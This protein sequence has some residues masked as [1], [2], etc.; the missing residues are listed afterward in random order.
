MLPMMNYCLFGLFSFVVCFQSTA[1]EL[2]SGWTAV[3]T[4][5]GG[6]EP[7]QIY[8][9]DLHS[10]YAISNS[11]DG[12]IF[13]SDFNIEKSWINLKFSGEKF[14]GIV[15]LV[16]VDEEENRRVI[17]TTPPSGRQGTGWLNEG[18]FAFDVKDF[19]GKQAHLQVT[20]IRDLNRFTLAEFEQSGRSRGPESLD[21]Y[22]NT[23]MERMKR[24]Q[25]IADSDP[26]RPVIHTAIPS[27]KSWDANG[28][29]YKDGLYH[30]FYLARPNDST[31]IMAHKV[32]PDLVHWEERLPAIVPSFEQGEEAVWSG[33][34]ILD[35]QGRCH[36]Y[37]TSVGPDRPTAC[38]PHQGHEVSVDSAFDRF[39]KVNPN[40]IVT[41]RDIPIPV[42][43]VRDPYVFRVGDRYYMTITG[44]T[45]RDEY[46]ED[47]SLLF[48]WDH[49]KE[50][51]VLM[52]F[53]SDDLYDWT[54][55]GVAYKEESKTGMFEVSDLF[56]QEGRWFFSPGGAY[57]YVG[58]FD[59]DACQFTPS[60]TDR[61]NTGLFYAYR[62][63]TAPDGRRLA[64]SR[65]KEGGDLRTKKWEGC[66]TLVREWWLQDDVLHQRPAVENQVLRQD[67]QTFSGTVDGVKEIFNAGTE[68]EVLAE[69]EA[70]SATRF[71]LQ[72]RRSDDGSQFFQIGWD[73][74]RKEAWACV[75]KDGEIPPHK[76]WW[77]NC[78]TAKPEN[79]Q[80]SRKVKLQ[81][82][83]DRGLVEV[84]V[85]DQKVI[86]LWVENIPLDCTG[87]AVFAEN[88]DVAVSQ[89]DQWTLVK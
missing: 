80:D 39:D 58:S 64:I 62:S 29:V 17:R 20:G 2:P 37:Y 79:K 43:Q 46:K 73:V 27:G 48:H 54:Y 30:F 71:G 22:V 78:L 75:L 12:A 40:M 63:M 16:T 34:A 25:S 3:G 31:P 7:A 74:T 41:D 69:L 33:S 70:G 85:D 51:P 53:E 1:A 59:F 49:K 11:A 28:F 38:N 4:R 9:G 86:N 52:L 81:V 44:G 65:I 15:S 84:F 36:I 42:Q 56:E 10:Y 83:I 24:D 50:M 61:A 21:W 82:I 77:K 5:F 47:T 89:M 57:Y 67:H 72:V 13:S 60:K 23:M 68:C 18:W 45:L 32:S 8:N 6:D 87:I 26:F 88:G 66:Y 14:E 35:Q 19:S 76:E 55:R